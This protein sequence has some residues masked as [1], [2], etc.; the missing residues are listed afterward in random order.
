[1]SRCSNPRALEIHLLA[2]DIC[3]LS[4]AQ[5]A[6]TLWAPR[7]PDPAVGMFLGSAQMP[8]ESHATTKTPKGFSSLNRKISFYQEESILL[9]WEVSRC[10][11]GMRRGRKWKQM[12]Y[13]DVLGAGHTQ[14]IK[15]PFSNQERTQSVPEIIRPETI[16]AQHTIH[17]GKTLTLSFCGPPFLMKPLG[18][19]SP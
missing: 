17:K 18:T 12:S 15:S 4:H 14:A 16:R 10:P 3:S 9:M 11:L 8:T 6:H 5:A 13:L 7:Q 2:Q 19:V 1:M